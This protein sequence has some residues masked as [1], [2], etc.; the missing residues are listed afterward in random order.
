MTG[1]MAEKLQPAPPEGFAVSSRPGIVFVFRETW[2]D[3][4]ISQGEA[5]RAGEVGTVF[6]EGRGRNPVL[7]RGDRMVVWRHCRHGGM[8]RSVTSDRFFHPRRFLNELRLQAEA[9]RAGVPTAEPLGLMIERAGLLF[10]RCRLATR[11]LAGSRDWL[12]FYR[13][14]PPAGEIKD[15]AEQR[16]L[17]RGFG[18]AVSRLHEAGFDHHDLQLKNLLFSGSG[19]SGGF[20][21]ID[22]DRAR[23]RKPL[24]RRRR[25]GNLLRLHRSY[26][27]MCFS[28]GRPPGSAPARFLR[29]Y[30]PGD[31]SLRRY[32]FERARKARWSNR[33]HRCLWGA[34][35]K[36]K[37]GCY[38][39]SAGR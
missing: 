21:V 20:F 37:G 25:A 13:Q 38:A 24:G 11:Y 31:R 7:G 39:R 10:V 17:A 34:S 18:K 12:S 29:A 23:R 14:P 3:E 9:L 16:R 26:L 32:V 15:E 33:A 2:R 35:V 36:L 8:L 27:K 28:T 1:R 6:L 22:F 5:I 19:N 30:A 4:I